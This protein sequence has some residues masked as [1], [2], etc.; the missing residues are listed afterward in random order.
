MANKA[1]G[2]V[3]TAFVCLGKL[4]KH[5]VRYLQRM[6]FPEGKLLWY[7]S[8]HLSNSYYYHLFKKM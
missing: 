8:S 7:N 4:A 5:A 6:R 3:R 1:L 2:E